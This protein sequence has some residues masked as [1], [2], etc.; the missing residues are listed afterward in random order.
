MT[1]RILQYVFVEKLCF[2]S[3]I[4]YWKILAFQS[5]QFFVHGSKIV[6]HLVWKGMILHFSYE[7]QNSVI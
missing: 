6:V 7:I 4:E 3:F 1:F 5:S 2:V